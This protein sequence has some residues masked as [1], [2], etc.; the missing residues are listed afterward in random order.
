MENSDLSPSSVQAKTHLIE[1]RG[2]GVVLGGHANVRA[3]NVGAGK[4]RH[5][6]DLEGMSRLHQ[7]HCDFASV[8]DEKFRRQLSAR[9]T[10]VGVHRR[11]ALWR[12]RW[13]DPRAVAQQPLHPTLLLCMASCKSSKRCG[14]KQGVAVPKRRVQRFN[15]RKLSP[16]R[17]VSMVTVLM[18]RDATQA[19]ENRASG[20][21]PHQPAQF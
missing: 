11:G 21:Q 14:G 2:H 13:R 15:R 18:L 4:N 20:E 12:L 1:V 16:R 19:N 7:P 3:A 6:R 10:L 8:R 9:T 5:R 17:F